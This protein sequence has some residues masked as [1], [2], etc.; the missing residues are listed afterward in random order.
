VRENSGL[1]RYVATRAIQVRDN[2]DFWRQRTFTPAEMLHPTHS[3]A[4][5]DP[6]QDGL[7]NLMEYALGRQGAT[8]D[9]TA[10][11]LIPTREQGPFGLTFRRP[12]PPPADL[13]YVLEAS[14][15]LQ[16]WAAIPIPVATVTEDADQ[17]QTVLLGDPD[18]GTAERRFLRLRVV[19]KVL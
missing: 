1:I 12:S 5:T 6:D 4:E 3:L 7:P 14:N 13:D 9:H 15:D 11:V 2:Y 10:N 8:P 19:R 18:V 16:Q 17:M